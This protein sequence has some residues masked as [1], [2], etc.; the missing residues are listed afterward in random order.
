MNVAEILD[1]LVEV[2]QRDGR[3][4]LDMNLA[5]LEEWDSLA[6]ISTI[7]LFDE[8][9]G[10]IIEADEVANCATVKDLLKLVEKHL[11]DF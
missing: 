2:L 10:E 3:L 6:I 4:A 8:L 11:D 7:S 9:F 1:E 5:E